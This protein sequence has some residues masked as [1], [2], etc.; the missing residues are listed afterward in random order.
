MSLNEDTL[1]QQTSADYLRDVLGWESVFAFG[2]EDFGDDSLLGRS[3]QREAVLRR[4]IRS[5]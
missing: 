2:Q 4:D 5:A 3:S 1:V